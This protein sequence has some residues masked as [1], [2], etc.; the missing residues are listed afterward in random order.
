MDKK[1]LYIGGGVVVVF[2]ILVTL[3]LV[4]GSKKDKNLGSDNLNTLTV[5]G[6]EDKK[7]FDPIINAYQEQNSN[8]KINYIQKSPN[9]YLTSALNEIAAGRGPDIWA[10]PNNWLPQYHD[11]LIPLEPKTIED[12]KA[13]KS[14]LEVYTELFPRIISQDT[15]IDNSVYGIPLSVDTLKIY[16]NPNV[17]EEVYQE[18]ADDYSADTREVIKITGEGPKN[19]DEFVRMV[20]FITKKSGGKI[21]RSAVALGTSNNIDN[22]TDIL[23]LLMLQNGTKMTS[24][25][26]SVAQFHTAENIFSGASYPGRR[27]LD[28][29]TSFSDPNNDNYTWNATMPDSL[30]AFAEGKTAM[31]LGYDNALKTVRDINPNIKIESFG[32][33]QVEETANPVDY[34]SYLV[35]TVTKASKKS[36]LA[37]NFIL[38]LTTEQENLG[39]YKT[40]S[41]NAVAYQLQE[42]KDHPFNRAANWYMPEPAKTDEAFKTMVSQVNEGGN[43]QTALEGAAGKITTLLQSLKTGSQ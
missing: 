2:I 18:H 30:R 38:A 23:S 4:L 5:W 21:E 27:A 32:L 36:A 22:Q 3:I 39:N 8:I 13:N 14:A 31:I 35:Y 40:I 20:R 1:I 12:K 37:W 9:E 26:L 17:I 15:V 34:A 19:W 29:Y 41:N 42:E 7:A 6:L 43:A 25:D 10:M 11:K 16:Y 33:P 28:F 24:D